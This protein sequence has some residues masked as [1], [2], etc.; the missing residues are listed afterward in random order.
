MPDAGVL[1]SIHNEQQLHRHPQMHNASLLAPSVKISIDKES[2]FLNSRLKLLLFLVEDLHPVR[3]AC[4]HMGLS[5]QKAWDMINRLEQETGY[6]VVIRQ[7]GDKN[8]G[9]TSASSF[10]I[11][12]GVC[13][14]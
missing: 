8:G 2:E 13:A 5:Y 11:S 12:S 7:H 14:R 4:L 6:A 3:Q 10:W 9:N 1:M